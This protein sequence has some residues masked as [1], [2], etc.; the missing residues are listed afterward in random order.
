MMQIMK[1]RKFVKRYLLFILGLLCLSGVI[2]LVIKYYP[3]ESNIKYLPRNYFDQ[4]NTARHRN[5]YF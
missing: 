2:A 3:K 5:K 1:R 4:R